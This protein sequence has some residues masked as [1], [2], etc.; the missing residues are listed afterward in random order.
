M[1]FP[2][3]ALKLLPLALSPSA[4]EGEWRN[5][6]MLFFKLLREDGVSVE[7]FT[8]GI[9]GERVVA[10]GF[11]YAGTSNYGSVFTEDVFRRPAEAL[12]KHAR[13]RAAASR[14]TARTTGTSSR[15][16]YDEDQEEPVPDPA[17]FRA[18]QMPFGKHCGKPLC[19]VPLEYL[20]W[21]VR[22][23]ES[24]GPFLKQFA[25]DEINYR[26]RRKA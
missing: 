17:R 12:R 23:C 2:V 15:K 13:E 8:G 18:Y 1:T 26:M 5:A 22:D 9:Q 21:L 25:R 4:A 11:R 7:A 20:Q 10:T 6:A 16:W 19:D 24:A 3:R 14:P